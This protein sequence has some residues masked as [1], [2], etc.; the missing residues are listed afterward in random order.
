MT[1]ER[2]NG[3]KERIMAKIKMLIAFDKEST[4]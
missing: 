1:A 3:I 2:K 4:K